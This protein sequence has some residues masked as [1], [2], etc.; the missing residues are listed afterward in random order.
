MKPPIV[1]KVSCSEWTRH[2]TPR[3]WG[4]KLLAKFREAGIPALP[5]GTVEYGT[6]RRYD[7]LESWDHVYY[8]WTPADQPEQ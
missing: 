2:I 4:D 6:L 1:V 3:E 5:N 8:E 7:D